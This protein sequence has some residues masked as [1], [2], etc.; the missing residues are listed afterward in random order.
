M[1]SSF[2]THQLTA[3][4]QSATAM[5]KTVQ[6]EEEYKVAISGLETFEASVPNG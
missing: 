5:A 1:P 3:A 2:S 4:A 6:E